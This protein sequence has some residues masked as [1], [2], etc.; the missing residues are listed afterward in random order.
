MLP[1]ERS[2]PASPSAPPLTAADALEGVCRQLELAALLRR[3][4]ARD[5]AALT[6]F[7]HIMADRLYSMALRMLGERE[8]AAEALQD[9]MVRLWHT[10]E[11]YDSARSDAF[12][13]SAMILRGLC[14]DRLRRRQREERNTRAQQ[15][16]HLFD[17]QESG[18]LAD[19][20]FRETISLVQQAMEKLDPSDRDCLRAALFR[21]ESTADYAAALGI[22]PGTMK[23]RI[24]R[25]MQRLRALLEPIAVK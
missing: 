16:R 20:F 3:M 13:W 5:E 19:L 17:E 12:T 1:R 6:A 11:R 24:H 25:A 21:P 10:A 4:A 22:S 8:A 15:Q 2:A 14:Y 9:V 7:Y 23:V 18:G